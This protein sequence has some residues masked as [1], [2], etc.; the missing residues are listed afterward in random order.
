MTTNLT[1]EESLKIIAYTTEIIKEINEITSETREEE[2]D[3]LI[4]ILSNARKRFLELENEFSPNVK[5][6][7]INERLTTLAKIQS[8]VVSE[9]HQIVEELEYQ[10]RLLSRGL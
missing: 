2:V 10:N 1:Q 4:L 3:R 8:G 6:T 5:N 9:K 7:E